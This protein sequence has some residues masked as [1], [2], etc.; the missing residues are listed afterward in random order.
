MIS[1]LFQLSK[2]MFEGVEGSET[3]A[4]KAAV[5]FLLLAAV[6]LHVDVTYVKAYE[7]SESW[8]TH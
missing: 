1:S 2:S 6:R 4:R 7:A 5:A 8:K 3:A